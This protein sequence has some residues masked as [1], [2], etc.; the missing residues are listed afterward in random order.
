M[1][2]AT[3]AQEPQRVDYPWIVRARRW[4][5][6]RLLPQQSSGIRVTNLPEGPRALNQVSFERP[7]L[8]YLNA[9]LRLLSQTVADFTPI[10]ELKHHAVPEVAGGLDT[11]ALEDVARRVRASRYLDPELPKAPPE[12]VKALLCRPNAMDLLAATQHQREQLQQKWSPEAIQSQA[13]SL[14]DAYAEEVLRIITNSIR[15][16]LED[17]RATIDWPKIC[18]YLENCISSHPGLA[19]EIK[20]EMTKRVN[21]DFGSSNT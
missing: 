18:K 8:S 14:F 13:P 17:F 12:V 4:K 7:F 6:E 11:I 9:M 20:V 10:P 21:W 15:T 19:R 2:V 16:L 1:P 3:A 5:P